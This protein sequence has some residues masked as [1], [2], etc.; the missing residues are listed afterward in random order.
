MTAKVE[1]DENMMKQQF[2]SRPA[3]SLSISLTA[4]LS[5]GTELL[6]SGGP[7]SFNYKKIRGGNWT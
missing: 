4:F 2:I 6:N 5:P 3:S 1:S 7:Q